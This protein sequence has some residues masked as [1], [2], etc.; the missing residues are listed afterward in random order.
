MAKNTY[1]SNT[2]KA[3]KKETKKRK[4]NFSF[5]RD[6][7]LHLTIGLFLLVAS[8]FLITAFTSYLFTGRADQSV[9]ESY[10]LTG[11]RTAGLE[12]ENW[13]GLFGAFTA[14]YFI[15]M[16]FG[17]AAFLIPPFLF[18]VGYFIIFKHKLVSLGRAFWFSFFFL[19]W[20]STLM[21]YV[22]LEPGSAYQ[23]SFLGGGMGYELSYA[24][25]GLLGWGTFLLLVFSFMVFVIYF[26]N[27]TNLL[28]LSSKA[29]EGIDKLKNLDG[30]ED[31]EGFV[32]KS[33]QEIQ[34]QESWQIRK[35][36][37]AVSNKISKDIKLDLEPKPQQELA[38]EPKNEGLPSNVNDG[39]PELEV[40][41]IEDNETLV[42]ALGN[43]DPTLDLGSYRF[44]SIDLLEQYEPT[45]VQ[46][47][48]EELEHNK[49]KILETL[50]NFKIGIA[51]IK[52]TIGP[53]VTL[54]EIVPDAGV[55]ISRIKNL[56]DDIALSLSALGIRIIAPIPGKGTIGIE[57]PNKNR[58]IVSV[59]SVIATEKFDKC[60]YELPVILGKTISNE[61]HITDL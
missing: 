34:E 10:R 32:P 23:I 31:D 26:F 41:E 5:F 19:V 46:V 36:D 6:R 17:I 12:V 52:A 58:E 39:L 8:F 21:G 1:K 20:I 7:R 35:N 33:D 44:P 59:R 48:K 57:V 3:P 55:K 51:S 49:D 60:T 24:L 15:F 61:V 30:S 28:G 13:F 50:I 4:F 9:V 54:Y 47:S 42:D 29:R 53:T 22:T 2:F 40:E 11:M 18:V 16:W 43:Y 38:I 27:I 37:P 56:E 14:H 25:H 45:N